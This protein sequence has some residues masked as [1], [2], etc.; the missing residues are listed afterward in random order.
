MIFLTLL[1][2]SSDRLASKMT[3]EFGRHHLIPWPHYEITQILIVLMRFCEDLGMII[4]K[5]GRI[6]C[7]LTCRQDYVIDFC[8]NVQKVLIVILS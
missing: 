2:P 1:L 3:D 6:M 8:I 4:S 7:N 5:R